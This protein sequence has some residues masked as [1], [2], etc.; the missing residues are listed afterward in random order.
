VSLIGIF[1]FDGDIELCTRGVVFDS[2]V[3][4]N[5]SDIGRRALSRDALFV[6]FLFSR[7][8]AL[9]SELR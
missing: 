3:L 2:S 8:P 9:L 6:S 7:L 5:A 1:L 4:L